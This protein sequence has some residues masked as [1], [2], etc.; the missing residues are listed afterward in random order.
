MTT[1]PPP[2]K[3]EKNDSEKRY[4]Y[5]ARCAF[6]VTFRWAAACPFVVESAQTPEAAEA[7]MRAHLV[8][9]AAAMVYLVRK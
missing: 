7:E 4:F 8:T 3:R 9:H 5:G 1:L 6:G 2:P